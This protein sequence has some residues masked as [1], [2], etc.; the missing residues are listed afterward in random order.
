MTHKKRIISALFGIV[1]SAATAT[2]ANTQQMTYYGEPYYP[3]RPVYGAFSYG[4]GPTY[5]PATNNYPTV[6]ACTSFAQT[7]ANQHGGRASYRCIDN[8]AGKTYE[9]YKYYQRPAY[10]I[11]GFRIF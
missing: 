10:R 6:S 3:D 1:A 7:H 11:F 8:N 4:Y 2:S 5:V 9:G